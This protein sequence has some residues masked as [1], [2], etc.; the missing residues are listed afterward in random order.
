[1]LKLPNCQ[2]ILRNH[3][4]YILK[5]IETKLY[6]YMIIQYRNIKEKSITFKRIIYG[7]VQLLKP[8]KHV[9]ILQKLT[10]K[11]RCKNLQNAKIYD[12]SKEKNKKKKKV[13]EPIR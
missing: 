4:I 1:M 13:H 3:N 2:K 9:Q 12:Y 6:I 10:Q 5:I 8:A 7:I 11:F